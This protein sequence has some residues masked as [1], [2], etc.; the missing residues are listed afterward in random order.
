M[1]TTNAPAP[2]SRNRNPREFSFS[3]PIVEERRR[4]AILRS[5]W[6][7]IVAAFA[8]RPS[9]RGPWDETATSDQTPWKYT[10]LPIRNAIAAA[11]MIGDRDKINQTVE[12]ACAFCEELKA[13]FRSMVPAREEE[14]AVADSLAETECEGS[15]NPVQMA[16]VADPSPIAAERA[17]VPLERQYESLGK[18]IRRLR[19][20]ARETGVPL[21]QVR[22]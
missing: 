6:M 19:I 18:L 22:K 16:Y 12:A 8:C 5:A 10:L 17:V 13:D 21:V 9:P 15:A 4:D 3:F 2:A 11:I 20:A 14:S 1:Q 7:R